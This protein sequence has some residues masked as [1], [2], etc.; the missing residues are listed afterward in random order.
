MNHKT[1]LNEQVINGFST[2]DTYS[3][4]RYKRIVHPDSLLNFQQNL[5]PFLRTEIKIK[6][7]IDYVQDY[8]SR[9]NL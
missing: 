1:N 2:W 6:R 8:K 3:T 9:E 7:I 5:E 4:G